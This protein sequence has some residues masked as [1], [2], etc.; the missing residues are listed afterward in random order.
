MGLAKRHN[1]NQGMRI[2]RDGVNLD[3][4]VRSL[5]GPDFYHRTVL[6]ELRQGMASRTLRL[7][8]NDGLYLVMPGI[9]LG[10][11]HENIVPQRL[12]PRNRVDPSVVLHYQVDRQYKIDHLPPHS[13]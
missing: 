2:S 9:A 8:Y 10:V 7:S 4:I 5:E 6:L 3:V 13:V 1:I 12:R 11:M